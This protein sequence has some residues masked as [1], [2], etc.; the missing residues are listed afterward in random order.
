MRNYSLHFFIYKIGNKTNT[1]SILPVA[2]VDGEGQ[3]RIC[4]EKLELWEWECLKYTDEPGG[5][6]EVRDMTSMDLLPGLYSPWVALGEVLEAH[7]HSHCD[8]GNLR[9]AQQ[10]HHILGPLHWI[11]GQLA[12]HFL[13]DLLTSWASLGRLPSSP[14][15]PLGGDV[16]SRQ[17][18]L[19]NP[20]PHTCKT[21]GLLLKN[22]MCQSSR[23]ICC[24]RYFP[25]LQLIKPHWRLIYSSN[26]VF[27][28][29]WINFRAI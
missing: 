19:K 18:V 23:H 11:A 26:T 17:T 21:K 24:K 22:W 3:R 20:G 25:N 16:G 8:P 5:S 6:T 1:F 14:S 15:P 12:E 7:K 13:R 2:L 10:Y 28:Q 4:Q 29:P 9:S 27:F